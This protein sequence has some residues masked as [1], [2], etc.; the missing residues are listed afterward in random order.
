MMITHTAP[1]PTRVPG[2][3]PIVALAAGIALSVTTVAVSIANPSAI[4]LWCAA[5][6]GCPSIYAA[7][8]IEAPTSATTARAVTERGETARENRKPGFVPCP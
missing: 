5:H 3:A 6:G 8:Q 1:V 4:P 7:P 2:I